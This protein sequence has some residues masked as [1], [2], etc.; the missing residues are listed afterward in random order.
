[1]AYSIGDVDEWGYALRRRRGPIELWETQN[2]NHIFYL[3]LS[4]EG[5]KLHG[6]RK[7]RQDAD[8]YSIMFA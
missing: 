5:Y 1:M 4:P 6:H 7:L 3:S 2:G 8:L